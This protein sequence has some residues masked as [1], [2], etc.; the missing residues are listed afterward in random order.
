[1]SARGKVEALAVFHETFRHGTE[2]FVLWGIRE[3]PRS[4]RVQRYAGAWS[5]EHF[6]PGT[7][8]QASPTPAGETTACPRQP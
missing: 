6:R 2:T 3:R 5:L 8:T 7:A 1:M 4:H